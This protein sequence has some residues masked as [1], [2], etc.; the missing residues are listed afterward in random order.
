MRVRPVIFF[1]ILCVFVVLFGGRRLGWFGGRPAEVASEDSAPVEVPNETPATREPAFPLPGNPPR[2]AS[3]AGP[4]ATTTNR[5]V[6]ILSTLPAPGSG[7]MT[8]LEQRIDT[9]QTSAGDESQKPQQLLA[10]LPNLP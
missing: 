2:R 3:T 8:D 5:P 4:N 7:V 9:L 1:V 6:P 10:L